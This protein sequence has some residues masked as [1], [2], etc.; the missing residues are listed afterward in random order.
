MAKSN[1]RILVIIAAAALA[2]S[3]GF[4][5]NGHERGGGSVCE[6]SGLIGS[7]YAACHTYCEALD[8]DAEQ[9]AASDRAC[10]RALAR[11]ADVSDGGQPPCVAQ[12]G[13]EPLACPCAFGWSDPSLL[14]E[15]W[16]PALCEIYDAGEGGSSTTILGG[17][18]SAKAVEL[19]AGWSNG[20]YSWGSLAGFACSWSSSDSETGKYGGVDFGDQDLVAGEPLDSSRYQAV[21]AAC[22][23]DL[24]AFL[25]RFGLDRSFC[26]VIAY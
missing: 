9:H 13:Q 4:A 14:P 1:L 16:Q 21:Y 15:G 19:S 7:A 26:T 3:P 11:F 10:E 8:C 2:A 17:P 25:A 22:E 6:S 5:G 12:G 20:E 18:E 23:S 24:M